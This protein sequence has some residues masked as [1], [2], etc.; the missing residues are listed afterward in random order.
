[1][2]LLSEGLTAPLKVRVRLAAVMTDRPKPVSITWLANETGLSRTTLTSL[3]Y[4]QAKGVHFKTLVTICDALGCHIYD[5]LTLE[6][7]L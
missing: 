6:V 4:N 5:L 3:Y 7:S 1:M 2:Q